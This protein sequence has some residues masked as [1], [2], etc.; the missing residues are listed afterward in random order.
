MRQVA[1]FA[2]MPQALRDEERTRLETD[3][4]EIEGKLATNN[5][6]RSA[7]DQRLEEGYKELEQLCREHEALER[8]AHVR[9]QELAGIAAANRQAAGTKA[10]NATG[11]GVTAGVVVQ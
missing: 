4:A 8:A 10:G 7:L 6:T 2:A 3:V 9:R 5:S 11:E 1:E